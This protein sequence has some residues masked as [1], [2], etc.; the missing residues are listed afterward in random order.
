MPALCIPRAFSNITENRIR[1]I[2]EEIGLGEIDKIIIA[3]NKGGNGQ[4]TNH[5]FVYLTSWKKTDTAIETR[6][7]LLSGEEIKIIYDE[8]WFWKV[9]AMRN[10]DTHV[11]PTECLQIESRRRPKSNEYSRYNRRRNFKNVTEI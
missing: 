1:N 2:F 7:R 11:A 10:M 6:Q 5:I 4:P 8:P 3:P 9:S